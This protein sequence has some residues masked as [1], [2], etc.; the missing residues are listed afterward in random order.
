MPFVFLS[1]IVRGEV[2]K[3]RGDD[4]LLGFAVIENQTESAADGG[5]KMRSAY[6]LR[7]LLT[8]GVRWWELIEACRGIALS[9]VDFDKIGWA[10]SGKILSITS[11]KWR[12]SRV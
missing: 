11:G 1:H 3:M 7:R 2:G 8:Q 5:G 12:C 6:P 4:S 9:A 10:Y